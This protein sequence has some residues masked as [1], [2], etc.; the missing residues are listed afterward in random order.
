[1]RMSST[2][3]TL[4]NRRGRAYLALVRLVHPVIVWAMLTRAAHRL[5][6]SPEG[7]HT[8]PSAYELC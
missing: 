4:R 2:V 5:S 1:M 3:V 6:R 8:R 7:E